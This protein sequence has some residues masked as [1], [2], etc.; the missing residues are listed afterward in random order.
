MKI[1]KQ[2]IIICLQDRIE[3]HPATYVQTT[4]KRFVRKED[5]EYRAQ[6]ISPERMA[7]VVEIPS[8]PI[9]KEG[10]PIYEKN[11]IGV[12]TRIGRV[13]S[14]ADMHDLNKMLEGIA[15]K[16]GHYCD[17]EDYYDEDDHYNGNDI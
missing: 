16:H 2:Y 11:P 4:R 3:Q 6:G 13:R 8:V 15:A 1:N 5:A 9:D 14:N 7:V 12:T 17:D 10:Y